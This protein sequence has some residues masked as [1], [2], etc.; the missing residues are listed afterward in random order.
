MPQRYGKRLPQPWRLIVIANTAAE[1]ADFGDEDGLGNR[2]RI[3]TWLGSH[4]SA[5]FG[6]LA[7]RL[8]RHR[9]K[10][11]LPELKPLGPAVPHRSACH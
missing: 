9:L 2:G 6:D 11:H 5:D 8:L 7:F 1:I 10:D 4:N 3:G